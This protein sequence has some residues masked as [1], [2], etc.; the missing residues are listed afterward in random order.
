VPP[1]RCMHVPER[2]GGGRADFITGMIKQHKS[3]DAVLAE[4]QPILD[5]DAKVRRLPAFPAQ[6]FTR[7]VFRCH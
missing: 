5:N 6:H 7:I 2:G 4:V 1:L 3:P